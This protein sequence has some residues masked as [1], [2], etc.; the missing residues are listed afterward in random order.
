MKSADIISVLECRDRVH[1]II[2]ENVLYSDLKNISKAM[3]EPFP[4]LTNF[5]IT[6]W[7][8]ETDG[9]EPVPPLPDSFLGGSAPRLQDFTLSSIPFPALQRFRKF[10][11]RVDFFVD[12]LF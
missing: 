8:D 10:L 3:Q 6:V 11:P 1:E 12:K 7:H 5:L 2:F 9:T 4:E